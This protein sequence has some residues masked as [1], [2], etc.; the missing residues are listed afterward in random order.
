MNYTKIVHEYLDQGPVVVDVG[1]LDS[2]GYRALRACSLHGKIVEFVY[3]E[4]MDVPAGE[5]W[6]YLEEV[7]F[8]SWPPKSA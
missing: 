4:G 5:E 1:P 7:E 2:N 3:P 8:K 6:D